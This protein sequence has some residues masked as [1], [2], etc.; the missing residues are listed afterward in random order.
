MATIA[1]LSGDGGPLIRLDAGLTP[2]NQEVRAIYMSARVKRWIEEELPAL[3]PKWVTELSP[4]EQLFIRVQDFCSGE[5]IAIGF[6]LKALRCHGNGIWEIKTDDIRLF[7][8]F[9]HKDC[10]VAVHAD[11]KSRLLHFTSMVQ[12][13]INDTVKFRSELSLDEPNFVTG[14]DPYDVVSNYYCP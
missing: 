4:A 6:H 8:W 12:S 9:P 10:F 2:P 7:G 11:Q 14:E 5:A 3:E 1:N 13:Y